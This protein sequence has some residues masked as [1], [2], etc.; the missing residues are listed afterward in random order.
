VYGD[1]IRAF[2]ND[3]ASALKREILGMEGKAK[4]ILLDEPLLTARKH[5]IGEFIEAAN[6]L[7]DNVEINVTLA[8]SGGDIL[9]IED[10]LKA[11]PFGGFALD[12]LDGPSNETI[13]TDGKEWGE[14]IIQLGLVHASDTYVERPHDIA[15]MLVKMAQYHDPGLIWVAPT[16]GMNMLSRD[17]AYAKLR[18]LYVGAQRARNELTRQESS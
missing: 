8:T 15:R 7:C 13:L 18:S 4:Y 9:G 2:T 14:R 5:E 17:I 11:L 6:L 10:E 12:M 1:D 16:G 3:L